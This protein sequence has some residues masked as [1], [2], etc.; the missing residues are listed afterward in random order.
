VS[1]IELQNHGDTLWF[2][3]I[4]VREIPRKS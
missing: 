2:K 3:N 1:S 4:Y